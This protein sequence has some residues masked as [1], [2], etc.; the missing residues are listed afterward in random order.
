MK[1]I[2]GVGHYGCL[3]LAHS[4]TSPTPNPFPSPPSSSCHEVNEAKALCPVFP[5]PRSSVHLHETKKPPQ[6]D[7]PETVSQTPLLLSC[8]PQVFGM[9]W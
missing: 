3:T 9:H 5:P 2:K 6:A 1:K 4:F 8:L 7:Q